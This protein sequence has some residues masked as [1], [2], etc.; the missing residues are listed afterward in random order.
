MDAIIEY[1]NHPQAKV[2]VQA[3]RVLRLSELSLKVWALANQ[4]CQKQSMPLACFK[5]AVHDVLTHPEIEIVIQNTNEVYRG[6]VISLAL[7]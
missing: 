7:L 4:R 5:S 1:Q 2:D 3:G 6:E